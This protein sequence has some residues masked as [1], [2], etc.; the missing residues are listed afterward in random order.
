ME[1]IWNSE[2]RYVPAA[3]IVA[4]GALLALKG[5]RFEWRGLHLPMETVGKNLLTVRG[6]RMMLGGLSL[7]AIGAGWVLQW[8]AMVAAGVVI[9]IEETI[10]TSIVVW[11]LRQEA[12]A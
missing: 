4:A 1:T 12:A 6:M 7:A 11:A 2:W 8:P 9:G 10:E 3:V 5:T